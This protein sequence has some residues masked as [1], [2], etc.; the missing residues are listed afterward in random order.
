[1]CVSERER[2][3]ERAYMRECERKR[4]RERK[5]LETNMKRSWE[6]DPGVLERARGTIFHGMLAMPDTKQLTSSIFPIMIDKTGVS[7]YGNF[8]RMLKISFF[9]YEKNSSSRDF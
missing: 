9:F 5:L 7:L 1:M 2:E 8:Y 3:S 6:K 4:K